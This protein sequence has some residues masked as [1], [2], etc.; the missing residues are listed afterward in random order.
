M[1][2]SLFIAIISLFTAWGMQ[3]TAD[4]TFYGIGAVLQQDKSG[5]TQITDLVKG[6]PAERAGILIGEFIMAV[7]GVATKGKKLE[8]IVGMIRG[9]EGTAV[10][11][12]LRAQVDAPNSRDVS[13]IRG[14]IVVTDP[15]FMEGSF[16]LRTDQHAPMT[17]TNLSGYLAGQYI[18]WNIMGGNYVTGTYKGEY[19]NLNYDHFGSQESISG[20]IHGGYIRWTGSDGWFSGYQNCI[21]K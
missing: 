6:G 18:S 13:V 9:V 5:M 14:K 11:L 4:E 7:D 10:V 19:V 12:N 20:Y 1:K 21:P 2:N 3:A 15:C 17:P 8:E 16:N